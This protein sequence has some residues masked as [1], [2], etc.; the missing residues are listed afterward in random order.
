M[1]EI[2]LNKTIL[3]LISLLLIS[4][5]GD[6][7]KNKDEEKKE[8]IIVN[9]GIDFFNKKF[10][11]CLYSLIIDESDISDHPIKSYLDCKKEGYFTLHYIPKTDELQHFWKDTFFKKYD[12][13]TIDVGKDDKKIREILKNKTNEYNIFSYQINKEYLDANGDCTEE[14]VF[15]N[16]NSIANIYYYNPNNNNWKLLKKIKSETLPPYI[17]SDFFTNN[18]SEYF[19][20]SQKNTINSTKLD[21]SKI[22]SKQTDKWRGTYDLSIDYGKL[23]DVSEMSIDYNIEIKDGICTFSGM[24]YKTYFTDLCKVEGENDKLILKYIKSTDG[25]GFTDHSNINIIGILIKKNNKYFI[26]SPI[27]ANSDWK[28][29]VE[30]QIKKK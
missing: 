10:G 5:K 14:S 27:I 19:G 12:F 13:N 7:Q 21:S 17:S 30:L 20:L 24:G 25:D 23:D 16:K 9:D 15:A 4:C 3:F 2:Q 18:F 6:A 28:Y 1:V 8:T 22:N 29:D 26:K 11:N